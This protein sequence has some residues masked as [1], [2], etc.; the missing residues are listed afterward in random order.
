MFEHLISQK[1]IQKKWKEK[2]DVPHIDCTNP[3]REFFI[4]S[5]IIENSSEVRR[6]R[7]Q[8]VVYTPKTVIFIENMSKREYITYSVYSTYNAY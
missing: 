1:S 3:G 7:H 2:K 6:D 4:Q 8:T 5:K